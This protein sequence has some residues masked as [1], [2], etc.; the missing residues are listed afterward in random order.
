MER[1][2]DGFVIPLPKDKIDDYKSIAEKAGALWKEHGALAYW[3]CIGE[4]LDVKNML[5]FKK[6]AGAGENDTVV[7]AWIVFESREHRDKVN[8]AVMADPRINEMCAQGAMP[9]DCERMVY[10][11]FS[12]LVEM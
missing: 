1:Y 11:G 3:E 7:F 4:D 6:A 10:G 9:V 5:S 8:S 12:K 2:V